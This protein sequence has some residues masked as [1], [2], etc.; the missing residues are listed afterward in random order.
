MVGG[1]DMTHTVMKKRMQVSHIVGLLDSH[2]T[3]KTYNYNPVFV[4]RLYETLTLAYPL[5]SC[6]KHS[7]ILSNRWKVTNSAW[8]WNT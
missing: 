8:P 2:Y 6:K 1:Q 3:N 5:I 4:L 7:L